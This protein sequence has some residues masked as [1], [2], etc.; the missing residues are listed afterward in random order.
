MGLE[1]QWSESKLPHFYLWRAVTIRVT[2]GQTNGQALH[3]DNKPLVSNYAHL[4]DEEA[5]YVVPLIKIVPFFTTN[6]FII[7]ST[8]QAMAYLYVLLLA[9]VIP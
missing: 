7:S 3:T 4:V 9:V 1:G 2:L 6:I 5:L 8:H